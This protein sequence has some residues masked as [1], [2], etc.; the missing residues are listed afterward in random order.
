MPLFTDEDGF[1]LSPDAAAAHAI[2]VQGGFSTPQIEAER[3]I[4]S[5]GVQRQRAIE[6]EAAQVAEAANV[7]VDACRG[8]I[9]AA[10]ASELLAA[11]GV[12]VQDDQQMIADVFMQRLWPLIEAYGAA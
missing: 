9:S 1:F 7:D 3:M 10:L 5:G 12:T 11:F 2:M 4:S 8:L 6:W